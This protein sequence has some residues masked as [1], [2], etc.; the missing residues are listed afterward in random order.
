MPILKQKISLDRYLYAL[1]KEVFTNPGLYPTNDTLVEQGLTKNEA[2]TVTTLAPFLGATYV[3]LNTKEA[4]TK[5]R[6]KINDGA[7]TADDLNHDFGITYGLVARMVLNDWDS[8]LSDFY[9]RNLDNWTGYV[10]LKSRGDNE[11][12][13]YYFGAE[14]L[15][16][17]ALKDSKI[18]PHDRPIACIM[19]AKYVRKFVVDSLETDL[20][21]RYRVV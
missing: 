8:P 18:E 15:E 19:F 20:L 9:L 16:Q 6:I 10:I 11:K 3:Y 1:L 12:D 17:M 21:K 5:R 14:M 4:I 13:P 7:Q 2:E